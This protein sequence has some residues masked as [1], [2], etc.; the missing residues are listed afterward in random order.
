MDACQL[1]TREEIQAVQ[2]SP[3]TGTV[4]SGRSDAG[5]RVSQCYFAAEQSNKSVS[6]TVTQS[7][8]SNADKNRIKDLWKQTFGREHGDE[9]ESAANKEKRESLREQSREKEEEKGPPP[10]KIEGVGDEAYWVGSRVGGALYVL[11]KDTYIRVSVGGPD[12]EKGK[13]D[14][15]KALAEKAI[16]RF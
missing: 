12:D 5:I 14:K 11:K 4:P 16:D 15:S 2:G 1:L 8:V 7:D 6:L 13:I 9:K 3:I 10:K